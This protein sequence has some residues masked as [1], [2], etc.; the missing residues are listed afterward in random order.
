MFWLVESFF[1]VQGEGRYA[2]MPSYF[3]R[4][5]GC[6]LHC[7]GFGASYETEGQR[8]RGCDT[9]F[10]VD[11]AFQS[12]W[13]AIEDAPSLL[14]GLDREFE[15][16]GY[17]PDV[18]ITGGEPL[19]YA[20]DEVFYEV[21][22]GLVDR[23]IRVTFETNATIAPDFERFGAYASCIFALSVKL[24]NSGEAGQRRLASDVLKR[25]A[26]ESRE[27]FLKFTVDREL[28]ESGS[29]EE[30]IAEIR[31]ILPEAEIF[32]MPVG[33]SRQTLWYNDRA[34]F[35]FCLKHGYR[36]SDR[37]HI[38]IFDMTQGV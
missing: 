14:E 27:Y 11:R 13:Q 32:C 24:S 15:R 2:G 25:I 34:V 30:E 3:L 35:D 18:V 20:S 38:R 28:I 6:N 37:L 29:A 31:S 19:L 7:P 4:T 23:G 21:V 1:S 12:Q 26:A 33:E 8:R 22:R 16:I 9:W 36:Y 10:A 17:R 5:G